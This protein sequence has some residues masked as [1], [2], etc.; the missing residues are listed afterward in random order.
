[1]VPSPVQSSPSIHS[2]AH[3]VDRSFIHIPPSLAPASL[4]TTK[5]PF[6]ASEGLHHRPKSKVRS[7]IIT[8]LSLINQPPCLFRPFHLL[9]PFL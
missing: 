2:F 4:C 1:L 8:G 5:T 3:P 7:A 6:S 9:L